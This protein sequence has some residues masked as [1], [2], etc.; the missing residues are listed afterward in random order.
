MPPS[1][2]HRPPR[3]IP[4]QSHLYHCFP[5]WHRHGAAAAG[6]GSGGHT[7]LPS[8]SPQNSSAGRPAHQYPVP[9]DSA[10]RSWRQLSWRYSRSS[11]ISPPA[12]QIKPPGYGRC[13]SKDPHSEYPPA[14]AGRILSGW[15]LAGSPPPA[16]ALLLPD[17]ISTGTAIHH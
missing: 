5:L 17:N 16:P 11:H 1:V 13:R 3:N 8:S 4:G 14:L 15:H 6:R 2:W 12:H 7:A 9:R 10:S